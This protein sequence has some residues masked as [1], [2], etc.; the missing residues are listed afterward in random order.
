MNHNLADIAPHFRLDGRYLEAHPYGYGH[1]N[2]TYAVYVYRNG[3]VRRYILQR[4]ND[5]VFKEPEALMENI[6]RVTHHLREKIQ[7]SGGDVER[8]TLNVVPT[9]TGETF[10]RSPD[11]AYWRAYLF[12]EGAQTYQNVVDMTHVYN[13][14]KAFG[15]F[16]AALSDFPTEELHEVIPDF[17]H[18]RKRFETFVKA[19]DEDRVNRAHV[20]REEITFIEAR[21]EETSVLVDLRAQRELPRRVTHND[22]K[23]NN[24]M[25]DNETGKGICVIDLDTVMPGLALYDFGDAVRSATNAGAE[26][27]RDLSKVYVDLD[28]YEHL[29]R[30]YLDAACE[31]LTPTEIEYL[32][33]AAKLMTFENA[34]R[35]LTDYLQGDVYYKIHREHQNLDR[36]R[37]HL[38]LVRDMEAHFEELQAVVRR[39]AGIP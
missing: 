13:A 27:E 9:T 20:V 35:F 17:H 10:Y 33:F 3:E 6:V 2:D 1:I 15:R 19:L 11:G 21:A 14:A 25:I 34:I 32:P 24:V 18:T 22:T 38:Q 12:I 4:I 29:T 39:Y 37:A 7:R 8:E 26:D 16:Q 5:Y 28:V 30:G 31:F 36:C 23:F